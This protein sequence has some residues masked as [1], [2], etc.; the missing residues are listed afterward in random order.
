M[1]V[2]LAFGVAAHLEPEIL[3][4]DEVLAVGDAEFQKKA[5]GK[6]KDVSGR[7]GRTVLFVSHNMAAIQN[8]CSNALVLK[9][10]TT[11]FQGYTGEAIDKYLLSHLAKCDIQDSSVTRIGNGSVKVI[12]IEICDADDNVIEQVLSGQDIKIK[13]H[14]ESS[15][16]VQTQ[17]MIPGIAISNQLE[18]PVTLHHS[19]LN[20]RKFSHKGSSGVF[21]LAIKNLPLAPANYNLTYSIISDGIF[22]DGITNVLQLQ[23]ADGD[24]YGSGEVPPSSHAICLL[25]GTWSQQ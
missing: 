24:Y 21:V 23:V 17:N 7:E 5:L 9:N 13:L 10:G 2:R 8:L 19:R 20:K 22:L 6:M 25:D 3:I 14:Y 1:Y 16:L 12:K 15:H 4:V 11:F 18:V